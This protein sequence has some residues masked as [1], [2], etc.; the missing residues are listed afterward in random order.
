MDVF[1]SHWENHFERISC[2]WKERVG[3]EDIVLLPGDLSW[4]MRLEDAQEHLQA[5]GAL[6]GKK[7]ILR[8]NHDYWWSAIGRVR[9]VLPEEMYAVQN[10]ALFL[11]GV[12]ICGTRGWLLP[13]EGMGADDRKIYEREL[14][15]LEMSLKK[16]CALPDDAPLI[17]MMHFPPMTAAEPDTA[18]TRL[19]EQYGAQQVVY[20]HLHGPATR[21]AF[22]GE[23]NGVCYH[24]VSCDALGFQ[25]RAIC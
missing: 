12:R 13:G 10:D 16:A 18:F 3:Q 23:H 5:I 14:L 21:T 11:E 8:G 17:V 9:A 22:Q 15:R 7:V 20:G 25:L 6:P 4:A 24:L 1:G 2:N 19:L